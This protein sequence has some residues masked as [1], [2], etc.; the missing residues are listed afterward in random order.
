VELI[1]ASLPGYLSSV[2]EMITRGG[3]PA[4][5]C[6]RGGERSRNVALLLALVGVQALQVEG[7][8]KAYRRWV[9]DSLAAWKPPCPVFTLYGYTGSGKS[10]VLRAI[11]AYERREAPRSCARPGAAAAPVPWVVDLEKLAL[12]R[13]SLLGGLNQPGERSQRDF[14]GLLWEEL[15]QPRGDYLLLEG[16]GAKIGGLVLPASVAAAVREGIPV[17]VDSKT[18]DRTRRIMDEYSPGTWSAE[19]AAM[20]E[21]GLRLIGARLPGETLLSLRTGFDDGRFDEVVKGLLVQYYDPLYLRSSVR[22][23]D[24]VFTLDTSFAPEQ[25]AC[26]LVSLIEDYLERSAL[27]RRV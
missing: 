22:G 23:R 18:E 17:R 2:V 6:W 14:E 9:M 12:H 25:D 16:E 15:R 5:M 1:A 27:K 7:G 10:A 21:D 13:G 20:F 24:F 8:Y 4:V 11:A 19:D 3:R 26:R